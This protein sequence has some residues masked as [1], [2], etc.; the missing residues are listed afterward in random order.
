MSKQWGHG[1]HKAASEYTKDAIPGAV[2]EGMKAWLIRN[3]GLGEIDRIV[4]Q[5]IADGVFR[6]LDENEDAVLQ[7]IAFGP[8]IWQRVESAARGV[9]EKEQ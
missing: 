1:F 8:V 4:S 7:A 9:K 2:A 3:E 6:W 5:G